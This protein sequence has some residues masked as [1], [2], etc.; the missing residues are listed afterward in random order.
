MT[1]LNEMKTKELKEMA[2]SLAVKN[3]W[4]LKKTELIAEIAIAIGDKEDAG[5]E[6]DVDAL[7]EAAT[8]EE[9]LEPEET[10]E[11]SSTEMVPETEETPKEVK[12]PS[13][14][15]KEIEFNGKTQ[16][17][18][19]WAT[20]LEMPWPTLYDRINRNGWT[21]EEALTIPLGSRRKK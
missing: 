11:A 7:A 13:L 9:N 14:G 21:I 18:R 20:E 17:L 16:S 5:E 12:K 10:E 4:N 2:K 1:N 6:V 3:W 19:A 8:A 15:I